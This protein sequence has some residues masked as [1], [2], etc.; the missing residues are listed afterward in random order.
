M[1][2]GSRLVK[3]AEEN[4]RRQQHHKVL[5]CV[6]GLLLAVPLHLHCS[7]QDRVLR[8]PG[9]FAP[10]Q[11]PHYTLTSNDS[12]PVRQDHL[13]LLRLPWPSLVEEGN[14][15]VSDPLQNGELHPELSSHLA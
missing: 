9:C 12:Q 5:C 13:R 11:L 14:K 4:K 15:E 10:H 3:G 2:P 1:P 8:F 6:A 7:L